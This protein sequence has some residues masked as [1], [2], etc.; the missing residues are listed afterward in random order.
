MTINLKDAL[1]VLTAIDVSISD[2]FHILSSS[3]ATEI[4]KLAKRQGYKAPETASG[5][6]GRCYFEALQRLHRKSADAEMD[7]PPRSWGERQPLTPE[8]AIRLGV[9]GTA[10]DRE[11]DSPSP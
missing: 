11:D 3:Q 5:S 6:T 7:K 4:A 10:P 2:D 9:V 1:P 8:E